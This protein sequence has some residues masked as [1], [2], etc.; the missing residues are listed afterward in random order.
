MD[1]YNPI[2]GYLETAPASRNYENGFGTDLMLK[3]LG[4]AIDVAK[5]SKTTTKLGQTSMEIF[6][7]LSKRGL[8]KKDFS[9]IFDLLKKN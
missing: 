8:G 3:D 9:I 6:Q 5:E 4:L 7:E 1:K 2:P